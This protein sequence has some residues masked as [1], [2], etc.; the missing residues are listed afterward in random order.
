MLFDGQVRAII[1]EE[2]HEA[3]K[4]GPKCL[5][6][7]AEGDALG[8]FGGGKGY[9]GASVKTLRFGGT[10]NLIK[11]CFHVGAPCGRHDYLRPLLNP[12]Q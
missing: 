3:A 4:N 12:T 9:H 7:V 11:V 2:V 6:V 5:E 10:L 1:G 8:I